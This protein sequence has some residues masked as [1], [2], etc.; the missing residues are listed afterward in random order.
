MSNCHQGKYEV[1]K[2]SSEESAKKVGDAAK[3][4]AEAAKHGDQAKMVEAAAKAKD[5][6]VTECIQRS[7]GSHF[8]I[9]GRK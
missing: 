5:V 2:V 6:I 1:P 7:F 3:D 8:K 9:R 4:L